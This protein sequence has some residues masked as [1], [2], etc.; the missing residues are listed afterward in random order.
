[1]FPKIYF[2][3]EL[4]FTA[5]GLVQQTVQIAASRDLTLFVMFIV[6]DSIHEL[7]RNGFN[8]FGCLAH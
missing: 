3:K 2:L 6:H 8:K 7:S 1:M 4:S 5:V